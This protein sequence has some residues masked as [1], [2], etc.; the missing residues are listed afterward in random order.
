MLKI[1]FYIKWNKFSINGNGN[2]IGDELLATSLAN[3]I[4]MNFKNIY[5]EVYAPNFLP[6]KEIDIM[7]YLQDIPPFKTLAKK[8]ILY[9]Q[10]GFDKNYK[11]PFDTY[12]TSYDAFIC[13][14]SKILDSFCS[15]V[16]I[17]SLY[18]PFG[19]D[20]NLFKPQ[21][22]SQEPHY[23]KYHFDVS[24]IGN[25][26]KGE[27]TTMKYLFPAVDFNFGLF[28]N[29][30]IP[31]HR[32]KIWKNFKKLPPYKKV[33]QN[34]SQGKIPQEDVPYLYSQCKINLNCTLQSC[35]DW[36][37][38]TLR[39]LEILCCNG[40]LISDI[41]PLAQKEL[42]KYMVFTTGG[43]D[44]TDKIN[45]F[46]THEEERKEIASNGHNFIQKQYS[47]SDKANK[48]IYFIQKE[49]S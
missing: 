30:D 2:V 16:K 1:G 20:T 3:A 42:S 12:N 27:E 4:N 38:I 13:F 31:R 25:D 15:L 45:Y 11:I 36:D 47:I 19:V 33:F 37:V 24:Y 6:E 23:T 29:W 35:I 44:L 17:P 41:V 49:I 48:L 5:A 40:F 28:G 10:N 22:R 14:S 26:I 8:H 7:I 34:I 46:L 32:F 18:L 39:T 43:K 21:A 9:F